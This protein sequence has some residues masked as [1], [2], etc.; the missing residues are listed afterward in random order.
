MYECGLF[1]SNYPKYMYASSVHFSSVTA[2]SLP[3]EWAAWLK[4]RPRYQPARQKFPLSLRNIHFRIL[5]DVSFMLR[6]ILQI[7]ISD[8]ATISSSPLQQINISQHPHGPVGHL[9]S[10]S[11]LRIG[12]NLNALVPKVF[13]GV[14]TEI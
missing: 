1:N 7:K 11:C 14:G 3:L 6:S 12:L 8:R 10:I 13:D 4:M 9:F 5:S 2:C